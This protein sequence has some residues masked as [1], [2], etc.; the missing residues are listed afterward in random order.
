LDHTDPHGK[1]YGQRGMGKNNTNVQYLPSHQQLQQLEFEESGNQYHVLHGH[2]G[3]HMFMPD[4]NESIVG[5]AGTYKPGLNNSGVE[6]SRTY[7]DAINGE[8]YVNTDINDIHG[9]GHL[10]AHQNHKADGNGV[11]G[12]FEKPSKNNQLFKKKGSKQ[13]NG[14][15]TT[16]MSQNS[17]KRD[18]FSEDTNRL[19]KKLKGKNILNT[20][21][22]KKLEP[23]KNMD[24]IATMANNIT[25]NYQKL[26]NPTNEPVQKPQRGGTPRRSDSDPPSP[27]KPPPTQP[28]PNHPPNNNENSYP[29]QKHDHQQAQINLLNQK[30]PKNTANFNHDRVI[31]PKKPTNTNYK[32]ADKNQILGKPPVGYKRDVKENG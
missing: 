8:I 29:P 17:A 13:D 19:K 26:T 2:P 12:N 24:K 14:L 22:L 23:F 31:N 21:S 1:G 5:N 32:N 28:T 9:H 3:G 16:N 15:N 27:Q 10:T 6:R 25:F 4:E 30:I 11:G 20:N 7:D 18:D